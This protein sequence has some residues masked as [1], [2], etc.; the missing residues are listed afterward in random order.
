MADYDKPRQPPKEELIHDHQPDPR[1]RIA[2]KQQLQTRSDQLPPQ[3]RAPRPV[4]P[5]LGDAGAATFGPIPADLAQA[6]FRPDL[7]PAENVQ[8]SQ[9]GSATTPTATGPSANTAPVST[10]AA[11]GNDAS[12]GGTGDAALDTSADASQAADSAGIDPPIGGINKSGFIDHSDGSNIRTGPAEAGGRALTAEPLPP[13]TRVFVSGRHPQAPSWWYVSAYLPSLM[14]R[15]YVQDFRVNTEL[16]E[17]SAKLY[18]I[19]PGDTA[20]GLAVREFAA[21]IEPG[22]DLRYYEN[23]LL[24]V[25]RTHGRAGIHGTFQ[26][27]NVLGGG[28]DNIQLEAGRRIWLVSPTYARA[29][30]GTVPDGSLT[31]GGYAR[32]K[33]SLAHIDDLLASVTESPAHF[34]AVA[35]EYAEAIRD[36]LPEIIAITA[37]FIAAESAS[38]FL[39]ATPTG[40]GQLA[41]VVIQLGLAALGAAFAVQA[42]MGAL[43]HGKQW[44]TLAWTANGDPAKL[45]QASRAFLGMLVEIAMAALAMLGA[46]ANAGKGLHVAESVKITPPKLG[47][48]PGMVTPDGAVLAGGP[49]FTP[50]SVT[51]AGAVHIGAGATSGLGPAG[52]FAAMS[53]SGDGAKAGTAQTSKANAAPSKSGAEPHATSAKPVVNSGGTT[54]LRRIVSNQEQLLQAAQK[55]AGGSLDKLTEFKPGWWQGTRPDGTRV[56]IEW[57]TVGHATT[58]EGPHVTVRVWDASKGKKGRW[59]VIE[60]YFIDGQETLR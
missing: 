17:P 31:G 46:R 34:D 32:A 37:G 44:L 43:E 26:A 58:N 27:P 21:A 16:P 50:G 13:A 1:Q 45:A 18:Q 11:V 30:A 3:A 57:E 48:S 41:A 47:W 4:A 8:R 25:N 42:A 14:V 35:G 54:V 12:A 10:A 5:G 52:T 51:S 38:A 2:A 49:V 59:Q 55:A 53:A 9:A 7:P 28:S 6:A 22:R 24:A 40:V 29:L 19:Q 60:K 56:K 20:E 36:H 33:A 39:A 23:V 15:G